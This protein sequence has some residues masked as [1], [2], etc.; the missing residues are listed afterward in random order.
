MNSELPRPNARAFFLPLA[1]LLVAV[2]LRWA[3]LK[4]IVTVEA[5]ENFTPWMALAF[6]GTLV[7]PRRLPWF[8]LPL[9]LI[10]IDVTATGVEAIMDP[11][12]L[13]AYA[14]FAVAA[15]VAG[16]FR[17]KTGLLGGLAGVLVSSVAF[18]LITN[19]LAWAGIPEYAKTFSGWIQALTMGVP[20]YPETYWF[21]VR[22]L[23]SDLGFS[24]LLFAA[25]NSEAAMRRQQGM[26]LL[27]GAVAA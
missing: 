1:M 20:G 27:Q 23:C 12:T 7:F 11:G 13:A 24:I 10:G 19:T 18:Y 6:A 26:P 3:K 17:G 14:C 4:G 21:L 8:A 22:S 9:V 15:F 5:L 25:Y 2:L 16:R